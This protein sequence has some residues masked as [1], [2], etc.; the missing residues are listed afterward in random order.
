MYAC[1][2]SFNEMQLFSGFC[3]FFFFFLAE[4]VA[5]TITKFIRELV[6]TI[7]CYCYAVYILNG[8]RGIPRKTHCHCSMH[9]DVEALGIVV[10]TL[11]LQIHINAS[12]KK[13]RLLLLKYFD[14]YNTAFRP[15]YVW[16]QAS[17]CTYR[18]EK[19]KKKNTFYSVCII[20]SLSLIRS[21]FHDCSISILRDIFASFRF[22]FISS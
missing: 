17:Y 10:L 11:S 8:C 2:A 20:H 7:V 15:L 13:S 19:M 16:A 21:L 12:L 14:P 22:L 3:F 6:H 5:R 9:F 4:Y 1:F 18:T